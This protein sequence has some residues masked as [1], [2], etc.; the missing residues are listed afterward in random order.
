MSPSRGPEKGT[1][2]AIQQDS[3]GRFCLNDLHKAAGGEEKD[4]PSKFLRL[5]TTEAILQELLR[6]TD[7]APLEPVNR[8]IGKGKEQGTYVVKELVYAY[9]MWISA[10]FHLKVMRA[11]DRLA[12]CTSGTSPSPRNGAPSLP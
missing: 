1:T 5:D 11:Y 12:T 6:G 8:V 2:I 10:A 3:E 9:A 4:K 7:V